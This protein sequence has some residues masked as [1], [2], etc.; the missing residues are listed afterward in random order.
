MRSAGLY[1]AARSL[2]LDY[3]ELDQEYQ[4]DLIDRVVA[5]LSIFPE[6]NGQDLTDELKMLLKTIVAISMPSVLL[7]VMYLGLLLHCW[8]K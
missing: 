4:N 2:Q 1:S 5:A 3:A 8:Q 6:L 7:K